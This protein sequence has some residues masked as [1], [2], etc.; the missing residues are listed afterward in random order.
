MELTRE[1]LVPLVALAGRAPSLHNSQPWRFALDRG[2]IE[3]RVDPERGL[4]VSDPR[5]RELVISCGAALL[6]LRL[7]LRGLGL[8]VHVDL[9]PASGDPLLLA[10][11][12]ASHGDPPTPAEARMLAAVP[13][14]HTER[15]GFTRR[16]L[17]ATLLQ[18]LARDVRTEGSR[19]VIVDDERIRTRIT[20]LALRAEDRREADPTWQAERAR[21]VTQEAGRRDGIPVRA[22]ADGPFD[23]SFPL[24]VPRFAPR[25]ASGGDHQRIGAPGRL[26]VIT[27]GGDTVPDWISAG[28]GLQRL[29]LRAADT[30]V[31]AAFNTAALEDGGDRERLREVLGITDH[32]QMLFELGCAPST[33][34]TPR[35]SPASLIDTAIRL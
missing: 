26:A 8:D 32:P 25:P 30:W 9:V 3:L 17:P 31:F 12:R 27:T 14:R 10:R 35:L 19:L 16:P 33:H 5:A 1:Q 7:G 15:H 23:A 21:W 6:T 11:V 18:A 29:L 2:A 34:S 28:Q 24:P 4:S 22:L 13:H 20:H